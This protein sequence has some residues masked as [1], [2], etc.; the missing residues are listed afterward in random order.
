MNTS[1]WLSSLQVFELPVAVVVLL[2]VL[3]GRLLVD[4]LERTLAAIQP[5]LGLRVLMSLQ[6]LHEFHG[7]VGAV[8]FLSI[9]SSSLETERALQL[10]RPVMG[11]LEVFHH[12]AVSR[13]P[14]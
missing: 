11:H 4:E 14:G 3:L 8:P 7:R 10:V 9:E 1:L 13:R 6:V 12:I 5:R 2:C